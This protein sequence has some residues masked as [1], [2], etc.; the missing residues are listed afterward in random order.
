MRIN[1]IGAGEGLGT[2]PSTWCLENEVESRWGN[3]SDTIMT[4]STV[5]R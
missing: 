3:F 2:V 5:Q 1:L 4:L